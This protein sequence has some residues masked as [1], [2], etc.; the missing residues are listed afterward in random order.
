LE[1]WD[2]AIDPNEN[3]LNITLDKL[4]DF[5]LEIFHGDNNE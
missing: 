5:P 2:W 4:V 1:D 3:N